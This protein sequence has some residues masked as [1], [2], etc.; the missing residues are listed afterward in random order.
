MAITNYTKDQMDSTAGGDSG[1]HHVGVA[2]I[3]D[4]AAGWLYNTLSTLKSRVDAKVGTTRAINTTSGHLT[5]GGDLSADRTFGLPSVVSAGSATLSSITVDAQGRVTSLS[6]G[7]PGSVADAS[8]TVKGATKLSATPASSTDPIAVGANDTKMSQG[9]AGAA[10]V[11]ALGTGATDA[12]AGN[13]SRF[14]RYAFFTAFEDG[15]VNAKTGVGHDPIF[16]TVTVD[17]IRVMCNTAPSGGTVTATV[18]KEA[19]GPGGTTSTVGAV[20]L[21]AAS[22][23]GSATGLSVSLADGDSLRVDITTGVGYTADSCKN[24]TVKARYTY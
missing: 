10:T 3:G 17:R 5:G 2:T 9:A 22:R 19:G 4:I 20:I 18:V 8:T 13:D 24:L 23:S 12:A 15:N 11:R 1:A 14:T 21:A 16:M 7:S 6:S